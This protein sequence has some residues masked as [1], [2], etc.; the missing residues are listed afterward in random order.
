MWKLKYNW[1]RRFFQRLMSFTSHEF[2]SL[3]CVC[4]HRSIKPTKTLLW[5]TK[6]IFQNHLRSWPN[7]VLFVGNFFPF[8]RKTLPFILLKIK[9]PCQRQWNMFCVWPLSAYHYGCIIGI[10]FGYQLQICFCCV[11][12]EPT[13]RWL[14]ST[15]VFIDEVKTCAR[16]SNTRITKSKMFWREE[17]EVLS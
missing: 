14:Q 7:D 2:L 6:S 17:K 1:V 15:Y 11:M 8:G 13:D 4:A 9:Q 12:N 3:I 5:K 10:L 16:K